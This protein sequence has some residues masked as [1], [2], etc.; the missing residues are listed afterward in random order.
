MGQY[1]TDKNPMQCCPCDFRQQC[2][3]KILF[4]VVLILL[5]Q[6]YPGQNPK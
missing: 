4:K 2:T 6:H 5:G 3:G 1:C